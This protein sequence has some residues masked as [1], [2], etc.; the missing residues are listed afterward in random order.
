MFQ[1]APWENNST[2]N[3]D[4]ND[5][6]I[7]NSTTGV[8]CGKY[9]YRAKIQ[10]GS[11]AFSIA[12]KANAFSAN[13]TMQMLEFYVKAA[14]SSLNLKGYPFFLRDANIDSFCY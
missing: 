5:I 10:R 7:A 1:S 2:T 12:K 11:V 4:L 9:S 3:G 8:R 13:S 6:F 14:N